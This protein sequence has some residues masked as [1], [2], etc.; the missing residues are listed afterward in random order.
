MKKLSISILSLS[1]L[2]LCSV[3][4]LTVI[5]QNG[6]VYQ[7]EPARKE[8]T[9]KAPTS[10]EYYD[11]SGRYQGHSEKRTY[12]NRTDH[13]DSVGRSEGYSEKS[14]YGGEVRHYDA[15]GRYQGSTRER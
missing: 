9:Y 1:W 7:T 15:W 4:A 2:F 12:S 11:S 5:D 6:S 14:P 8:P 3:N 10:K 13:Y